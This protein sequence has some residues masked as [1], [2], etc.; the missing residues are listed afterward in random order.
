VAVSLA[1]N[2]TTHWP[3]P[4][5]CEAAPEVPNGN[6]H[7]N[8]LF[9]RQACGRCLTRT[10]ST[11]LCPPLIRGRTDNQAGKGMLYARSKRRNLWLLIRGRTDN[12]AGKEMLYARSKRR[13][14]WLGTIQSLQNEVYFKMR[15][16]SPSNVANSQII[17]SSLHFFTL[18]LAAVP[19]AHYQNNVTITTKVTSPSPPRPK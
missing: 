6:Q 8:P 16:I 10:L 9:S 3:G 1:L 4:L 2:K 19:F 12:K 7:L 17:L 14:L 18:M 11:L 15:Y 5:S 13:K